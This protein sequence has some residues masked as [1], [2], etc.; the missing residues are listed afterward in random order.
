ML[1]GKVRFRFSFL[2]HL[3]LEVEYS[4]VGNP[5]DQDDCE[6]HYAYRDATVADLQ[7]LEV[8]GILRDDN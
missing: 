8:K 1:T 3:I 5:M 7:K 2:M 6:T 4:Y